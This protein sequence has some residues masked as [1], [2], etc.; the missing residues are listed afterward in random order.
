MNEKV[1]QFFAEAEI[2]I[3]YLFVSMAAFQCAIRKGEEARAIYQ[4]VPDPYGVIISSLESGLIVKPFWDNFEPQAKVVI[5]GFL[6]T[7][8]K[9][10]LKNVK[11]G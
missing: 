2:N 10:A 6:I 9:E 5:T 7:A 11:I 4:S 8:I 3:R 1:K